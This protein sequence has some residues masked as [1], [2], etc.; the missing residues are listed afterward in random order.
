MNKLCHEIMPK[1]RNLNVKSWE[2][3]TQARISCERTGIG[4][5]ELDRL[6]RET[7]QLA[8]GHDE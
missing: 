7:V 1:T 3:N 2:A 4:E 6:D 5:P 8:H